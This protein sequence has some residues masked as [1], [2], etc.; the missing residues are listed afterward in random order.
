MSDSHSAVIVL[1]D[2]LREVL[3]YVQ[4]D[5]EKDYEQQDDDAAREH[6]IVHTIRRLRKPCDDYGKER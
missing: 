2:D 4:P 5:E 6:H 1:L 3:D